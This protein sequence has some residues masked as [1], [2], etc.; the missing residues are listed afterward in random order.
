[1]S[2]QAFKNWLHKRIDYWFPHEYRHNA[3]VAFVIT[4]GQAVKNGWPFAGGLPGLLIAAVGPGWL[5]VLGAIGGTILNAL[6]VGL[7]A[8]FG[9]ATRGMSPKYEITREMLER[10]E[11]SA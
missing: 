1:M 8:W 5:A 6:S 4:F 7:A 2:D 10:E 3:E 11:G 9:K